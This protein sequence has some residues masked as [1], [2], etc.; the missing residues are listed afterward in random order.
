[1]H[2]FVTHVSNCL[3]LGILL[4][5]SA[6]KPGNVSRLADFHGTKYE[7]FLASAVALRPSLETAARQGAMISRGEIEPSNVGIGRIV[8]NAV[9]EVSVWQ[10]GGNTLLGTILLLSP[11]AVAAGM[12]FSDDNKFS[13]DNLRRSLKQVSEST[14]PLD[15]VAVYEA[16]NIANPNGLANMAPTLDVNDT[17]SKKKILEKKINLFEIFRISAS[18]DS[19]S[20]EWVENFPITFEIGLPFLYNQLEV[21]DLNTA[22]IRT[23]LRVLARVPD[24]LIRRKAGMEKAEDISRKAE[25]ILN[26][27]STVKGSQ[28]LLDFDK[29]LRGSRNQLNPGTTADII[30]AVLAVSILDGYR[31]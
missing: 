17:S 3:Q 29:E 18:Y 31:P 11:L 16:I 6:N 13:I 23:F 15:A 12:S 22:I 1:M 24:T 7:H 27:L 10:H 26:G 30:A 19:I 4:E 5:I 20:R 2:Q 25:K 28:E 21:T 8:K 14:S 9:E